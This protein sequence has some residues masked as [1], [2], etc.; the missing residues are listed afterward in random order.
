M[1]ESLDKLTGEERNKVYR[2]LRLEITP[3]PEG[4]EVRGAFCTSET[5]GVRPRRYENVRTR[6]ARPSRAEV[7]FRWGH[8]RA[9]ECA[10]L[11]NQRW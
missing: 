3:T 2:M 11:E 9:D 7:N 8:G 5:M 10:G 6:N 4:Y 1:P